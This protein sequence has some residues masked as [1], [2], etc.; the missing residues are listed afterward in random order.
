MLPWG[1]P[2]WEPVVNGYG[3][4]GPDAATHPSTVVAGIS[5][6]SN[7]NSVPVYR[8]RFGRGIRSGVVPVGVA[9]VV[10][11][12]SRFARRLGSWGRPFSD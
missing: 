12:G 2:R 8:A 10:R 4:P 6:P 11:P 5:A 9:R 7:F 1:D 3:R